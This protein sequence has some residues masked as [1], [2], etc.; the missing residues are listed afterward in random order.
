[1]CFYICMYHSMYLWYSISLSFVTS[2]SSRWYRSDFHL[3]PRDWFLGPSVVYMWDIAGWFV[4][5]GKHWHVGRRAVM[6]CELDTFYHCSRGGPVTGFAVLYAQHTVSSELTRAFLCLLESLRPAV[7][8]ICQ[9][10]WPTIG[11]RADDDVACYSLCP[12]WH[13]CTWTQC[14]RI[15]ISVCALNSVNP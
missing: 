2:H 1:M 4:V 7:R 3:Q 13:V 9:L 6:V 8:S 14:A 12:C 15:Y 5:E 11:S 10:L